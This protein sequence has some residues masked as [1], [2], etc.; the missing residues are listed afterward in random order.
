MLDSAYSS[1][2]IQQLYIYKTWGES[3]SPFLE[4]LVNKSK[5]G[6]EVKVILNFNPLFNS[7]NE[8]INQTKLFLEKNGIEV[9][10][11]YSNWSYFTNIHNKGI[12]VD[13]RTVLISSINWNENSVTKNREAGLII[14]NENISKFYSEVFFYDWNLT[15]PIE[16]LNTSSNSPEIDD[17]TLYIVVI[18]TLT[19]AVII[20]DWRKRQWT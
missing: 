16:Q 9:K 14:E 2:Y 3:T 19:F 8:K 7:T 6:I 13:N 1:I 20:R 15:E 4:K 10:F 12:I 17:N 11:I 18:F 5:D